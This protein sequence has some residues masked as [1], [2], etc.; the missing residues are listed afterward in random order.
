[1]KTAVVLQDL[2]PRNL[3][4]Q[5]NQDNLTVAKMLVNRPAEGGKGG[6]MKREDEEGGRRERK[7][8]EEE[9]RG[10]RGRKTR[11]EEEGGW[12]GARSWDGQGR[13]PVRT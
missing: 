1:M 13:V 7:K 11:E 4:S 2:D 6:R 8:R 3:D 9:E 12:R 5:M 10:R